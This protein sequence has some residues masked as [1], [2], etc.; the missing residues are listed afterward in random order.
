[1][2][3]APLNDGESQRP[4]CRKC[5]RFYYFNP[6]PATCCFVRKDDTLLLVQRAVEP[7]RGQWT[8]PGGFVELGE[9]TE[10]GAVRELYEE[11]GLVGQGLRL[12]G[13]STQS[14]RQSG[15]VTILGYLVEAWEGVPEPR[16]D[17][18][19]AAFFSKK[20]RPPLAF[21]AHR[22]LLAVFDALFPD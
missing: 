14:S 3:L 6:V 8:L 16:S 20:E 2:K 18:L 10:E 12:I 17:A 21:Q 19:A 5:N 7:C 11:T 4:F 1:M 15:A 13:A 22:D 9:T